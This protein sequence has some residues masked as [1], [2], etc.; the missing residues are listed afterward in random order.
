MGRWWKNTV[1]NPPEDEER[2][3]TFKGDPNALSKRWPILWRYCQ[4]WRIIRVARTSGF[5]F[6]F[7]SK[8]GQR[9]RYRSLIFRDY[10]AVRVGPEE[11]TFWAVCASE[12]EY[13]PLKLVD[14]GVWVP[15]RLRRDT[16]DS[17]EG[18]RALRL[19]KEAEFV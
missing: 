18:L 4:N 11:V 17:S 7:C 2:R 12:Q 19:A 14:M 10:V 3:V 9:M 1:H 15:G 16:Q 6:Y 8:N 13:K 5:K